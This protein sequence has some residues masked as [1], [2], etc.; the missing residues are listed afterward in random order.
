MV[1]LGFCDS[2]SKYY[3]MTSRLMFFLR[4]K[5]KTK[6]SC[7]CGTNSKFYKECGMSIVR[8]YLDTEYQLLFS[9]VTKTLGVIIIFDKF[10]YSDVYSNL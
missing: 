2:Y 3:N 5:N 8:T 4:T 1:P 10:D 6:E 7:L 9:M